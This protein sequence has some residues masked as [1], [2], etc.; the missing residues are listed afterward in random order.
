MQQL[1][2]V[3][4]RGVLL[5]L[6]PLLASTGSL[7]AQELAKPA[8]D[9]KRA[10]QLIP[11]LRVG[12][13]T[14]YL[15][16]YGQINKGILYSD[17]G[18]SSETYFPVDN[19]NSSSR[20]GLRVYS[21]LENNLSIGGNLE[22]EWNPYSTN[23][24]DQLNKD[25]YDWD[26]NLLRKA[27]IYVEMPDLGKLWFGQGSMA[28]D[29]TAEVD[30]SGT[31]VVG[32]SLVSDM[33][34]GPFFRSTDGTLSTVQIKDAFSNFDG[35]GRKLRVRYDT[36]SFAGFSFATSV[37]Q[38]V[39]PEESGT[40]VWDMAVRYDGTFDDFKVGGAI[41]FSRPGDSTSIYDA[42]VSVLHQPTGLSVT[43][44]AAYS[45][46]KSFDGQYGYAK[47][48]YQTD[49]FEVGKTAFSI[50]AYFGSDIAGNNT[51]SDSYGIQ[52]VQNIDYLQTEVYLGAR[53]Y[54]Y[55]DEA[56][57]YEDSFAFL[58]GARV[59]F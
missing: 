2:F 12:D 1:P 55:E 45:D 50:D 26:T 22:W 31:T 20:I 37:G 16:F 36:P 52:V 42:S 7:S 15:E 19:G 3:L 4:P 5:L 40:T 44:A 21:L 27:E 47:L 54:S 10:E 17:D 23:Y 49:I 24:V 41:G 8:D 56:A 43:L 14:A 9:S 58:A 11:K 33:A 51:D 25:D 32:Y 30:F 29:G 35:V 53:S 46:K 38:Q 39:V 59:K 57:D 28:S 48:G 6:F 18:G 34:G 13:D